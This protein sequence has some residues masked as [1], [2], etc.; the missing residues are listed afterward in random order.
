[1]QKNMFAFLQQDT[2][3]I[4]DVDGSGCTEKADDTVVNCSPNKD[5]DDTNDPDLQM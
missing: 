2:R 3:D 1:M 5:D 4:G